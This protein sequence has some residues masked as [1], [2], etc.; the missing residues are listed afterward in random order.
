MSTEPTSQAPR[1]R[2]LLDYHA[3]ARLLGIPRGTLYAWVSEGRVP[4]LRFSHRMVRFDPDEL[5]AWIDA[6]RVAPRD[7]GCW[8]DLE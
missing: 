6:K 5:E 3:A 1:R 8:D 2:P 4:H 7:R